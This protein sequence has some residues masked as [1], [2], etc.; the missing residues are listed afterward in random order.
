PP[1]R[2]GEARFYYHSRAPPM[3]GRGLSSHR[4][5]IGVAEEIRAQ[6]DGKREL[7]GAAVEGTAGPVH[8]GQGSR[9]VSQGEQRSGVQHARELQQLGGERH[10]SHSTLTSDL[11]NLETYKFD[12]GPAD[13]LLSLGNQRRRGLRVFH[14]CLPFPTCLSILIGRLADLT[15]AIADF[16]SVAKAGKVNAIALLHTTLVAAAPVAQNARRTAA[17]KWRR[18]LFEGQEPGFPCHTEGVP[19]QATVTFHD[20]VTGN[21]HRHWVFMQCIADS[22]R[23]SRAADTLGEPLVGAYLSIRDR[24]C[25]RQ[26]IALKRRTGM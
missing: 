4:A 25:C 26:N 19:S 17:H 15:G 10:L 24:G 20:A 22:P 6:L 1:V 21:N 16:Q 3:H 2:I 13:A 14:V 23:R 18:G 11:Q 5:M 9:G 7:L 8:A 12:K